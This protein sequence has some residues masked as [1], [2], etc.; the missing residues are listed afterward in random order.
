[1]NLMGAKYIGINSGAARTDM[2]IVANGTGSKDLTSAP[3]VFNTPDDGSTIG[4]DIVDAVDALASRVLVE[5][6]YQVRDDP[7]DDVDATLFIDRIVPS[8]EAHPN[9]GDPSES[10]VGGLDVA[11]V[12]GDTVP[13]VFTAVLPGTNVCFDIR[14]APNESVEA[15]DYPQVFIAEVDVLADGITVLATR[16][17]YFVVWPES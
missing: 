13:D 11:D 1:M 6:A 9:P 16:S 12:S 8:T 2:E 15:T 17:V 10:C 3:L 4:A 14:P 7:S 5:V